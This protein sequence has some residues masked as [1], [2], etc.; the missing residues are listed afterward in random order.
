MHKERE[1]LIIVK[2][3]W[4]YVVIFLIATAIAG[5]FW[6][7]GLNQSYRAEY[8]SGWYDGANKIPPAQYEIAGAGDQHARRSLPPGHGTIRGCYKNRRAG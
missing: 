6:L 8:L 5:A 7:L 2:G 1:N 4:S 3:F